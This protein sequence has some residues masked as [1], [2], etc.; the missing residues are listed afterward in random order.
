MADFSEQ[1][2]TPQPRYDLTPAGSGPGVPVRTDRPWSSGGAP[3]DAGTALRRYGVVLRERWFWVISAFLII[4]G[5]V[6]AGTLLRPPVYRATGSIEIRKQAAEMVP[7]DAL[8]Q[9]ERISDQYLQTE[10]GTLRSRALVRATLADTALANRLRLSFGTADSEKLVSRAHKALTIDPVTGSRIVRVSFES[11]DPELA[12]DMVNALIARHIGMRQEAGAVALVRL[13]EQADSVR[14][15]LLQAEQ[16][17]QEFVQES[18]LRVILAGGTEGETVP[19]ERLRRLQQEL[20]AAEAESYRAAAAA[21]S[22]ADARHT[23]GIES[24]LLRNLRIRISELEG[25]YAR[26]KPTFTDSFPR[27]KQL[28]S[29]LSQ[30][31]ALVSVEQRRVSAAMTGE[32]ETTMRRRQLLQRAVA[33]QQRLL[34]DYGAK[35]AEYE[36]RSRD[37]ETQTQLYAGLQQKR[38]EAALSS[39]LAS[40][41]VAVLDAAVATSSPVR[42]VPSRDIPLGAMAGLLLGLGLAFLREYSDGSLRTPDDAGDVNGVPLLAM[43]PAMPKRGAMQK[44]I[45]SRRG[46]ASSSWPRIDGSS[47]VFELAEA[48]RGLRTS[49]LYGG[50]GVVPRSLL[51]TSSVPGEGKTTVA[52]NLAISLSMLGRRIL[53]VDGDL[54]RP[55]LHRVFG[56]A[57]RSGLAEQLAGQANWQASILR[58]VC[59]G[60]DLLLSGLDCGSP[61]DL[62][63]SD[64]VD[65]WLQEV[66]AVY[67]HVILDAPAL[68]INAP[69]ARILSYAV[70]GVILVVRSGS[71][72]RDVV[73]RLVGQVPHLV[74]IVLNQLN[75][76]HLPEYY[77]RYGETTS[78][79]KEDGSRFSNYS[80]PQMHMGGKA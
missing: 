42:P 33:E 76:K 6:T 55:S 71:A 43:I 36:R 75:I 30:L 11:P 52:S 22:A 70:G 39:A 59:P 19:Q 16:Q 41:D 24:D 20:T 69:D 79:S 44:Q 31:D 61:A 58:D 25:E 54:R 72:S 65:A 63:S 68:F 32:L 62:L 78:S 7:M 64:S 14:A 9:F 47:P 38:K 34:E 2:S 29:E 45:A 21:T 12:A 57:R 51:V 66:C 35:L 5:G 56:V 26:M 67:D 50:S 8:F 60:V 46:V 80:Q 53:L 27:M 48:F 49:V 23:A 15:Q 77:A 4:S 1:G 10:Y 3:S 28:R 73:R 17:L 37:V 18:G 13:A 40:M 74:G